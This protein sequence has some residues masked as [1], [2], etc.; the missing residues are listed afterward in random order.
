MAAAEAGRRGQA[1]MP[2]RLGAALAD[3]SL[4]ARQ[5]GQHALAVFQK[6]LTLRCQRQLARAAVHQAHLQ[7]Q[8]QRVDAPRDHRRRHA[9]ERGGGGEAAAGGHGHKALDL[10]EAGHLYEK[11][12]NASRNL[13]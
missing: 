9:F 2:A 6:G 7:A 10:P 5:L 13:G 3:G 11:V 1:Q 8:L 4:G 12:R